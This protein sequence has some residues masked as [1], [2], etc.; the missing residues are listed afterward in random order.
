MDTIHSNALII[1]K[2]P[3]KKKKTH[4]NLSSTQ[5]GKMMATDILVSLPK[6][7]NPKSKMKKIETINEF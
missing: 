2:N 6:K 1:K 3:K 7:S 4:E 5:R